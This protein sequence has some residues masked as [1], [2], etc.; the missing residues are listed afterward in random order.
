MPAWL[1]ATSGQTPLAAQINQFFTIHPTTELYAGVLQASQATAGSTSTS[2]NGLYLAQQFSTGASQSVI[3]YVSIP[4][5]T[6]TTSGSSLATTTLSLYANSSGAPSGS[7]IVSTTV[8]AEYA[9]Q[10]S[11]GTATK[12]VVYPLPITGLTASTSYWLVVAAAG[13]ASSS[14]TWYRSNQTSG[15]ST[16][17][18]G[19]VWTAQS[20]GFKYAVYDQTA[21]GLLTASWEDSGARWTTYTYN[22]LSQLSTIAEYTVGQTTSGYN[23]GFRTLT[24]SSALLTKAV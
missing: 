21:S 7:P 12:S 9:N 13:G 24:Y 15:A 10:S 16:S 17:P 18:T 14:Y 2:T 5:T 11:G 3:G 20:Y 8:T 1:A 22:A 19:S 4:V 6:T 23:Q